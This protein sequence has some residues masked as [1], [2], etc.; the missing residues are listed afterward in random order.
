MRAKRHKTSQ[1]GIIPATLQSTTDVQGASLRISL[2]G[3]IFAGFVALMLTFGGV[4]AYTTWGINELGAT[5]A[6]LH[7]SLVPLPSMVTEVVGPKASFLV[8]GLREPSSL[9]R[10]VEHLQQSEQTPQRLDQRLTK[11]R[12]RLERSGWFTTGTSLAETFSETRKSAYRNAS[13]TRPVHRS[14]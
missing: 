8:V 11:M 13:A 3:K 10:A 4:M 2:T 6:R 7:T 14:H 12:E 9:K 1:A 5:L